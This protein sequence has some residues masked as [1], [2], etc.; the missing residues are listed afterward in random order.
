MTPARMAQRRANVEMLAARRREETHCQRGHEFDEKNT[1]WT[2]NGRRMCRACRRDNQL[3]YNSLLRIQLA[4]D[5]NDP[6]HGTST[7][8]NSGGCRCKPCCY[9]ASVTRKSETRAA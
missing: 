6:R 7:A 2:P 1:H 9:A 4:V 5:P 3:R 8:Y